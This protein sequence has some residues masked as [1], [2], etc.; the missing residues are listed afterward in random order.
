MRRKYQTSSIRK[1]R[2]N[3]LKK[4]SATEGNKYERKEKAWKRYRE[5]R[6]NEDRE[7]FRNGKMN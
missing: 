6:R 2:K 1:R 3:N 5:K 4:K 7:E